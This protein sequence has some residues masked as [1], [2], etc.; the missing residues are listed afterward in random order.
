MS[1]VWLTVFH[2]EEIAQIEQPISM[3]GLS[4]PN[5]GFMKQ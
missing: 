1:K 5:L 2:G 3:E 4:L